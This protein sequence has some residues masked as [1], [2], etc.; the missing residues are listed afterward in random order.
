MFHALRIEERSVSSRDTWTAC[1]VKQPKKRKSP[2]I[3]D[4]ISLK[5]AAEISVSPSLTGS[6]QL[7]VP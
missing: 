3:E 6:D 4:L 7:E 5:E 2:S 1:M